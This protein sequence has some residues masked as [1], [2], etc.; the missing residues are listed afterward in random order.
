MLRFL[1]VFLFLSFVSPGYSTELTKD[2]PGDLT[3]EFTARLP[4]TPNGSDA[5][6]KVVRFRLFCKSIAP[7]CALH[8]MEFDA[9]ACVKSGT[10]EVSPSYRP[11]FNLWTTDS[12]DLRIYRIAEDILLMAYTYGKY[13]SS[14]SIKFERVAQNQ[15]KVIKLIGVETI[16]TIVKRN[17]ALVPGRIVCVVEF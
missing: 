2:F 14:L 3:L 11:F 9:A 16:G 17:Y 15:G 6:A 13:E 4:A 7:W 1:I 12:D 5:D 10:K 8:L